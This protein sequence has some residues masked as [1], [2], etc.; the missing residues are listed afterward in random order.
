[1]IKKSSFIVAILLIA[2]LSISSV[3]A[4][5]MDNNSNEILNST[6]MTTDD[7]NAIN[8]CSVAHDVESVG[9]AESNVVDQSSIDMT[10]SSIDSV[11]NLDSESSSSDENINEKSSV[12]AN[13]AI[14]E[15]STSTTNVDN[16]D[17]SVSANNDISK[18]NSISYVNAKSE[19]NEELD[20]DDAKSLD[21]VSVA[22]K[23]ESKSGD[24]DID[25]L[26]DVSVAHKVESKSANSADS[27]KSNI[28]VSN[29]ESEVQSSN[30][31]TSMGSVDSVSVPYEVNKQGGMSDNIGQTNIA[32]QDDVSNPVM[33]TSTI[34]ASANPI[35]DVKNT[36]IS[37][38]STSQSKLT[39]GSTA[40][41]KI[42]I[43]DIITGAISLKQYVLKYKKLPSTVTIK[44]N[45]YSISIFSYLM[46]QAIL[47]INAGKSSK[48]TIIKVT[49]GSASTGSINKNAYKDTYL[50]LAKTVADA[51]VK[52]KVLPSY[53]S[54]DG[55]KADFKL[56][57]YAFAKILVFDKEN[58]R[59]PNYC[60]FDSSVFKDTPV[61]KSVS[62]S[63]II[64]AAIN[65]KSYT[66]SNGKLPSS[67]S[68]G[69]KKVSPEVFS[70]LMSQAI[71][72]INAKKTSAKINII[73]VKSSNVTGSIKYR[74]FKSTYLNAVNT[75]ANAGV[76]KKVLPS[77]VS[78]DGKKAIFKVYTFGFAKIL[79][80]YNSNKRL[81]NYCDFD[82]SVFKEPP[83]PVVKYV[84]IKQIA[85]SGKNV[86][87]YIFNNR[88]IPSYVSIAGTQISISKFTY[89]MAKAIEKISDNQTSSKIKIIS[90]S[91]NYYTG[92]YIR[93]NVSA[94][95]VLKISKYVANYSATNKVAPKYVTIAGK[96]ANFD[97]YTYLLAGNLY[98]YH[99]TGK[100]SKSTSLSSSRVS[101]KSPN[102]PIKN[103]VNEYNTAKDLSI[104]LKASGHSALNSQI[105]NLA[106]SLTKNCRTTQEKA[107]AIFK[108]V[109]D[110]VS[111]S[112]YYNS[113][114]SASGALSSKR[115]NCCDKSNLIVALCRASNIPARYCHSTSCHF[116]SGLTCGHVWAQ[117]LIGNKWCCADA[118]SS[119]NSL[120]Y[121][122]NWNTNRI[123]NVNKYAAVPF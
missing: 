5:A 71:K 101:E 75:V 80:F 32:S 96:K 23:L 88:R 87:N 38:L 1:M 48:I 6:G 99:V 41:S 58:K 104:Y 69:G 17:A 103:G 116:R 19:D 25:S 74:A 10:K 47:N 100:L 118:T 106:K 4:T 89:L 121:V 60:L 35:S 43:S 14:S 42:S 70:Y 122:V 40:S 34:A 37:S 91:E 53:V 119:S 90:V 108:Y 117:I 65:L 79:A 21:D 26:D 24:S 92:D 51:G 31:A 78:L 81:P 44:G 52:K 94:K 22:H 68:V 83:K 13:N 28:E 64:K 123:G 27:D 55:K 120:G 39:S 2:C 50:K 72:N 46:S 18:S 109:R 20:N 66:I 54:F 112:F 105:K 111:Y 114:K 82:S 102:Y 33:I 56:Y 98:Y 11:S 3:S 7:I 8:D 36:E 57:T 67:I 115:A 107:N 15:E 95:D 30:D 12:S 16:E 113:Q 62:V 45:K 76:N 73:D 93:T 9:S 85:N 77:Y 110:K 49:N 29:L 61:V 63:D 59:L 84:T 86:R 97:V